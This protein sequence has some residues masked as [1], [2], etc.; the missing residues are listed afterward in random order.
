MDPE[1]GEVGGQDLVG[2]L[3]VYPDKERYMY[4]VLSS[5]EIFPKYHVNAT[6]FQVTCGIYGALCTLLKD[7]IANGIYFVDELLQHTNSR[8]GEYLSYYMKNFTD[9]RESVYGWAAA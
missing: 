5:A 9:R 8:Y 2:V 3:P 1:I 7:N 6:Y 4:N